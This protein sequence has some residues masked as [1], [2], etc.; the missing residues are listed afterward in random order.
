MNKPR[1]AGFR[2][3]MDAARR[4]GQLGT[5]LAAISDR[6][7]KIAWSST[8]DLLRLYRKGKR[9]VGVLKPLEINRHMKIE[10][11]S[12]DI[13]L[14]EERLERKLA[15]R[16]N[17]ADNPLSVQPKKFIGR[18]WKNIAH[19]SDGR[20][21]IT[22]ATLP[23]QPKALAIPTQ[24][25]RLQWILDILRQRRDLCQVHDQITSVKIECRDSNRATIEHLIATYSDGIAIVWQKHS[26]TPFTGTI[27]DTLEQAS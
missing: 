14:I 23:E 6:D 27:G 12:E 20:T 18:M 3:M 25:Q 10:L 26:V 13:A 19:V 16:E 11:W 2:A 15:D 7:M 1:G 4:T 17:F 24:L 9:W 21:R 5:P 22:V 8:F